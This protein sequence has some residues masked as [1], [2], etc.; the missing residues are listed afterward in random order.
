MN[1][2]HEL[3]LVHRDVVDN[4][5]ESENLLHLELDGALQVVDLVAD[6]VGDLHGSALVDELS[7]GPLVAPVGLKMYCFMVILELVDSM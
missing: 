4:D 1:V 2:L 3:V 6:E 7:G 5:G